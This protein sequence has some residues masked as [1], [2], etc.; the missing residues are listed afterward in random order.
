MPRIKQQRCGASWWYS[1]KGIDRKKERKEKSTYAHFTSSTEC[2]PPYSA[3]PSPSIAHLHPHCVSQKQKTRKRKY[4]QGKQRVVL[5]ASEVYRDG[6]RASPLSISSPLCSFR[7]LVFFVVD[8]VRKDTE[9]GDVWS[10]FT[11][12]VLRLAKTTGTSIARRIALSGLF[13]NSKWDKEVL[14]ITLRQKE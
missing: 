8:R 10:L 1:G 4:K 12:N 11:W 3:N 5:Q 9:E 14:A 2:D 6:A 7:R 13:A